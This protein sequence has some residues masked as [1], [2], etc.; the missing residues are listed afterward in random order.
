VSAVGRAPHLEL[1]NFNIILEGRKNMSFNKI[2]IVGYLGRDP[3]LRV[4]HEA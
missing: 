4:R 2:T 1:N 3:E